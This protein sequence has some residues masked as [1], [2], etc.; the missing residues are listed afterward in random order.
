MMRI[1]KAAALR[2]MFVFAGTLGAQIPAGRQ[3][4]A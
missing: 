2:L 1:R 4:L 3:F